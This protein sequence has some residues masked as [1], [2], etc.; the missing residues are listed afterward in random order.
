MA[1]VR[2]NFK[3]LL[4]RM[5]ESVAAEFRKIH[6]QVGR[7]VLNR[8]LS[9]VPRKT[10]ALAAGLSYRV[11]P[12]TLKLRVG[13]LGKRLN[14]KLFYGRI[15]EFG[16]KGKTVIATRKGTYGRA[17]GMG[18]NVRSNRYKRAALNAGVQGAYRLKISP[19]PP[20]RFL[21]SLRR[22]ELYRPYQKLWG[23]VIHEAARG[24]TE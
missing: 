21:Y 5:P 1:R 9:R 10:G 11:T 23:R 20:R 16:R 19:L 12:K 24:T 22:E 17:R 18:L 13:I 15:M 4:S 7:F 14:Q 6:D 3:Q 8:A 2:G